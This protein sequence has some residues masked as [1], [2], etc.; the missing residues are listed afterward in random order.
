MFL[1]KKMSC[2]PDCGARNIPQHV[3]CLHQRPQVKET[4]GLHNGDPRH[5]H[6]HDTDFLVVFT[7]NMF[8]N[9]MLGMVKPTS[10]PCCRNRK[11]EV[12]PGWSVTRC[13]GKG[14]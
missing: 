13:G 8:I 12:D 1:K 4:G 7:L 5:L 6:I 3:L 2:F 10:K 9:C 11:K 14:S